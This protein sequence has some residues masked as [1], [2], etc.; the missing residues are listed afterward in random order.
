MGSEGRWQGTSI[1]A[2]INSK[3][4]VFPTKAIAF[5]PSACL[6]EASALSSAEIRRGIGKD[7]DAD[8]RVKDEAT[9]TTRKP[10]D[11][12]SSRAEA[13]KSVVRPKNE[14]TKSRCE[15]YDP[16]DQRRP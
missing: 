1:T 14:T 2:S 3:L 9:A 10:I 11:D 7:E 8:G 12:G 6:A 4:Y 5:H 13:S 15:W 16:P